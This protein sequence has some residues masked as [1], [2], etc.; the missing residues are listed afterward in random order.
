MKKLS[1]IFAGLFIVTTLITAQARY[2]DADKIQDWAIDAVDLVQQ[3][4]IMTGF[5]DGS[6]QPDRNL[7]RAEALVLLFRI[8]GIDPKTVRVNSTKS[9]FSDVPPNAWF[10]KAVVYATEKGWIKGFPDGKFHP[11]QE[12]NKAELAILLQRVYGLKPDN[13]K[14]PRFSDIPEKAWFKEAVWALYNNGLIRHERA[15][16]FFPANKVSRAEAAWIFAKILKMPR[17]MGT[18][19]EV[20]YKQNGRLRSSRRVA[21]RRKNLNFNK[22]GYDIEK[23]GVYVNVY[24]K[25]NIPELKIGSDW[26]EVGNMIIKNKLKDR[27]TLDTVSFRISF[28][29][30]VG[31]ARN[32]QLRLQEN[33]GEHLDLD[34]PRTGVIF[35]TNWDKKLNSGQE[36]KLKV[37]VKAK[38]T[39]GYYPRKGEGILYISDLKAMS[40]GKDSN[41]YTVFKKSP[42]IWKSRNFGKISFNPV[43]E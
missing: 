16:K 7:N 12:L 6:F 35:K 28:E 31:P 37:F 23:A 22:Q 2:K 36:Y 38:D 15:L 18:S 43:V 4:K 29:D 17:L 40:S 8:K 20:N 3:K 24:N 9:K 21:I 13:K 11:E 41:G 27:I 5:G 25:L 33:N 32:F 26:A 1:I 30:S 39:T 42:I 34:F 10:T 19:K 14:I